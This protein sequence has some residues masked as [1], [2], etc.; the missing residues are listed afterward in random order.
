MPRTYVRKTE[1][2][3]VPL[4]KMKWAAAAFT[5]GTPLREVSQNF[6]IDRATIR[7]FIVKSRGKSD[8]DILT[9]YRRLFV[10]TTNGE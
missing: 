6:N 8:Q 5:A 10:S 1:R 7:R 4:D 2:A 3:Q 9:R